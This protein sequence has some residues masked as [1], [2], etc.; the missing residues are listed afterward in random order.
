MDCVMRGM[1]P[2][3]ADPLP[4]ANK[5]G[6]QPMHFS[7]ICFLA[8]CACTLAGV[9]SSASAHIGLNLGYVDTSSAAYGRFRDYVDAAVGGNRSGD[10]TATDAAYMYVISGGQ[11]QYCALAIE[12]A[13]Q[14]VSTAESAISGGGT[15]AI[16]RD[17]YLYVG[18]MLMD[19][20]ITYDWCGAQLSS[21]Q[22]QRYSA[23]AEQTLYNVWNPQQASWGGRSY[24][25]S[26]WSVND[27][28]NNYHY[29]FLEATIYWALASDSV[30]L[31]AAVPRRCEAA[32]ARELFLG[33]GRRRQS[34]RA[35]AT[36]ARI[37][38]SSANI[39]RGAIRPAKISATRTAT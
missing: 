31:V 21:S 26:G 29:S 10:F 2:E 33:D 24:P 38:A 1:Y 11:T 4:R 23:Y 20:S 5:K 18:G 22:R 27:P 36:A 30:T 19:V 7:R 3:H 13:E 15:P 17:S 28:G 9:Y 25:W 32:G 8:V 35:R 16:A 12:V 34:G 14:Q 37:A 6:N 39:A